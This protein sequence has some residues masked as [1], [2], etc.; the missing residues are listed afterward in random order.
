MNL[1]VVI[2]ATRKRQPMVDYLL[3]HLPNA[4]VVW[5]DDEHPMD[6]FLRSLTEADSGHLHLEDDC[7]LGK[8]FADIEQ[9]VGDGTTVVQFFSRLKEDS[10]K[11]TRW[12][13]GS[14]WM[15]NVCCYIPAGMGQQIAEYAKTWR[16]MKEH[17]TGFDLLIADYLQATGQRFLNVVPSLV[18]HTP[19][20]S[21]LGP[22]ARN[23]ISPLFTNP[24][25][26][27][28]PFPELFKD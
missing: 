2:Q 19:I 13:S 16:R 14:R 27:A 5:G 8:G 17:P 11:G 6:T 21:T 28:H 3:H 7:T 20:Q 23:R 24:L 22:R 25:L 4:C 9:L 12:M 1:P 10:V 26:G 18:Q 15:Y